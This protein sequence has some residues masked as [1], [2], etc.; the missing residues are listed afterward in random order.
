MMVPAT[1]VAL[2]KKTFNVK[3][4]KAVKGASQ[5]VWPILLFV[6]Y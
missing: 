4:L 2:M 5:R 3:K 6:V 1:A